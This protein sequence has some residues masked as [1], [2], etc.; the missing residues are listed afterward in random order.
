MLRGYLHE[1]ARYKKCFAGGWYLTGDL[2]M[3]DAD[4]YFWFVGRGDDVIKSAGHLIGPFEVESALIEHPAVAE[5]A[6]IG[7]PDE[8]AGEIVKAYVALNPG[9]EPSEDLERE[10]RGLARKRLGPAVAPTEIVFRKNPAQDAVG[11]DHAPAAEGAR[12]R[13][14]RG[15]YL[16]AGKRRDMT[17]PLTQTAPDARPRARAADA[18][19]PRPPVRGQMRRA[20]HAGEDPRLPASLRRGR[21]DRGRGHPGAGARGPASS[22]PIASTA[23]RWCAAC[24]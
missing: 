19:D 1:E 3:R 6:V 21:G 16:H 4:G 9:Y 5:A 18:D 13:P 14:A 17:R 11:Q 15:R 2:A 20:L 8:T 10:I 7:I 23:M 24:R 22:P 12:T